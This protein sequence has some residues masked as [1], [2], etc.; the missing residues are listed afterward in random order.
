MAGEIALNCMLNI[1]S[2]PANGEPRLVYLLVDVRPGE[3]AQP[4]QA[5]V[6]LGIVFDVSESM[7]LPVLNQEQFEELKQLGQVQEITSDG[8]NPAS[9]S[10]NAAPS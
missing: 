8:V 10:A 6:N 3:T 9:A 1:G 5:P 7:R 4:L 2:V